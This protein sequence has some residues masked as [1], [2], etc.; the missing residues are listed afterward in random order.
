MDFWCFNY[1]MWIPI[2]WKSERIIKAQGKRRRENLVAL[3]SV[4]ALVSRGQ[5]GGAPFLS[6]IQ[7]SLS[8]YWMAAASCVLI[9]KMTWDRR[10]KQWILFLWNSMTSH[11]CFYIAS[12]KPALPL[13]QT[14]RRPLSRWHFLFNLIFKGHCYLWYTLRK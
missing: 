11:C 5:R 8:L 7:V 12:P 13:N 1:G 14:A 3:I 6:S 4:M 2:I 10:I 9:Q